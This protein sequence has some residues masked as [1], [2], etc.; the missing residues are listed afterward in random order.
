[1]NSHTIIELPTEWIPH[2]IAIYQFGSQVHGTARPTKD[3]DV[4]VLIRDRTMPGNKGRP[5]Q[6]RVRNV[7][8]RRLYEIQR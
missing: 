4:A 3:M 6:G 7:H 8:L 1:M 5:S 2:V